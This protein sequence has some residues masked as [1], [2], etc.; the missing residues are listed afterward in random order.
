M[1]KA[2]K[3]GVA[4]L[5][6]MGERHVRVYDK[7][8][9]VEL[10]ALCDA[11][12]ERAH[13]MAEKYGTKCYTS[14]EEMLQDPQLDAVDIVLPDRLH[15]DAILLA[16][17][18]GKHIMVEKPMAS[19]IEDA[20]IIADTLRGYDKTFM[21]GQILRFD[22]RYSMAR[23]AVQAGKL[24]IPVSVYARRNSHIIGPRHYNG[25]TNLVPHVMVHDIDAI[26]W[27]LG[28]KIKTV[29]AKASDHIF[30][31]KGMLDCVQC[32]FTTQSG[33][34]GQLEACWILPEVS[35]TSI[36]DQLEII[37]TESTVYTKNCGEGF[38]L[39][40]ERKADA[41]DSR[42]WPDVNGGVSGALYEELT[43]FI[44]CVEGVKTSMISAD[45]GLYLIKVV[46]AIE[47][48]IQEGREITI[49]E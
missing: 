17:K 44:R 30:H 41:V 16:A 2:V 39:L 7:M 34:F 26:Q 28:E 35:I 29:Y 32:M 10:Y 25:A 11:N 18:Y 48:S 37:G 24:G 13:A 5:G 1:S 22:P 14:V 36:D 15:R 31:D 3:I 46:A 38:M 23:E 40:D 9:V 6:M 27:I 4:G 8:P 45:D 12:P 42:H 19:T 49:D 43:E 20:K 47:R 33:L 21:I